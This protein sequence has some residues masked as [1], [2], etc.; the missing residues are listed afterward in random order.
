MPPDLLAPPRRA[1]SP[2]HAVTSHSPRHRRQAPAANGLFGRG[3][4]YVLVWSLQLV[5]SSAVSPVLAHLLGSSD[6]GRLATSIA[7]YQVFSVLMVFGLDQ[8]LIMEHSEGSGRRAGA[9]RIV[10]LGVAVAIGL[11]AVLLLTGRA[12]SSAAGFPHFRGIVVLA[13]L[14]SGPGAVNLIMM[15]LLR[16]EDRL[17]AFVTMN[18]LTS[19]GGQLGGV[20]VIGAGA[21]TSAAYGWAGV[22]AQYAALAI[23]LML[24]RPGLRGTL[25]R[26]WG[27]RVLRVGASMTASALALFLLNSGDRVLLQRLD[28]AAS[29]GRYQIAYVVGSVPILLLTFLNQAWLPRILEIR[30]RGE[31]WRVLAVSRDRLLGILAPAVAALVTGS[32]IVLGILAPAS[33]RPSSLV[34]VVFLVAIAAFPVADCAASTRALLALRR[35]APV[36]LCT[37]IAAAVNVALN[38]VLIPLLHVDGA[39]LATLAAFTVQAVV[40]RR[41]VARDLVLSLPSRRASLIGACATVVAGVGVVVTASAGPWLIVR[42]LVT[43]VLVALAVIR[44]AGAARAEI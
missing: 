19:V 24:I 30:D 12:W 15:A 38:I 4:I 8:A 35:T 33:Y 34:T 1:A 39:A 22:V 26:A 20:A 44:L 17:G 16:A 14:W 27:S 36:A 9:A 25:D 32:P 11:T 3:M 28:G 21:R 43:G 7:L 31:Q 41:Y 42:L 13:V 37:G 10:W 29:V 6:F 18:L 5:V 2:R 40:A 23:G